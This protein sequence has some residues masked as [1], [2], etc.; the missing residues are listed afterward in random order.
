M[1]GADAF[2]ATAFLGLA[3]A[4]RHDPYRL[5]LFGQHLSPDEIPLVLLPV[6]GGTLIVT[7]QRV[8]EFR[9]HLE[10]HGA[11]NVKEF[12]GFVVERAID[13]ST[14]RDV[15]HSVHPSTGESGARQVNDKLLLATTRGQEEVLV[16]RGPKSSLTEDE[17]RALRA[18]ILGAQPK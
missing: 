16:S 6:R 10:V 7:D 8:L 3:R 12:Q 1:R 15:R 17:F 2:D 4:A 5:S 11:W 18:A 14:L 9:A 13:R